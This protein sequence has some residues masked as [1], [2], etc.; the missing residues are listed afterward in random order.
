KITHTMLKLSFEILGLELK[1]IASSILNQSQNKDK[2]T[3]RMDIGLSLVQNILQS[4]NR[5]IWIEN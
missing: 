4:Y 3:D 5:C 1:M 2:S